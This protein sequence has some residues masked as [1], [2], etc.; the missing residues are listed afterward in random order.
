MSSDA[1][2]AYNDAIIKELGNFGK[3][4]AKENYKEDNLPW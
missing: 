2:K 1:A 4:E 3:V